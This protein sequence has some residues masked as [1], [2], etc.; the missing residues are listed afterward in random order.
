MPTNDADF[1]GRVAGRTGKN[2]EPSPS[3]TLA[4]KDILK[5]FLESD[6]DIDDALDPAALLL[7]FHEVDDLVAELQICYPPHMRLPST[8]QNRWR[9]FQEAV[10]ISQESSHNPVPVYRAADGFLAW[11][12]EYYSL[13]GVRLAVDADQLH[14]D[15]KALLKFIDDKPKRGEQLAALAGIKYS[16]ARTHLNAMRKK[17]MIQ[18]NRKKG[19]YFK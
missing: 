14:P 17:G 5:W 18:N 10:I 16:T 6:L 9:D 7:R 1:P 12:V 19:G 2:P 15:Q 8:G 11:V 13:E 3:M 4:A